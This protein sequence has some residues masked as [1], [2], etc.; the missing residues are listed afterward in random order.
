MNGLWRFFWFGL[1]LGVVTSH[2][3]PFARRISFVQADG[4]EVQLWGQGTEFH[5]VF[6]TLEGYTVVFDQ[7]RMSYCFARLSPDGSSLVSSGV[8][9]Q[10]ASPESLALPRHLRDTPA[11]RKADIQGRRMRWESL[12]QLAGAPEPN[13]GV[14]GTNSSPPMIQTIG[15][16][17]GLT[18][19][20]DFMDVPGRIPREE[21]ERFCNQVGYSGYGNRGSVRD[22]FYDNSTGMLT[23]TNVV[24]A[25]VQVPSRKTWYCDLTKDCGDQGRQLLN[26]AL[27]ALKNLPN[28][29]AEIL[30]ALRALS[31]DSRNRVLACNVFYAGGHGGVWSKG[32]WPHSSALGAPVE[33]FPGGQAVWRYQI[34]NLEDPLELGT[35]CHEN[36]HMLCNFP[37][38]Y[39]Y[40]D[41]SAGGAGWFCLMN[42]GSYAGGGHNPS[43][44]CAYLKL[45]AGWATVTELSESSRLTGQLT[46]FPDENCNHFYRYAKPGTPTEYF[47]LECRHQS[48]RDAGLPASGVAVWHIDE[49]GDHNNQNTATNGTHANYAITLVQADH[50]Y[51]LQRNENNG[52]SNDLFS[53][54]NQAPDFLN[55]IADDTAPPGNWWDGGWSGMVLQDFSA[56]APTMSF[57]IGDSGPPVMALP[58]QNA[59]VDLGQTATF[60]AMVRGARPLTYQW[61]FHGTNL[62]GANGGVL[63]IA[64]LSPAQAG[65]YRLMVSNSAGLAVSSDFNL[66][67]QPVS[68]LAQVLD[69]PGLLWTTGGPAGWEPQSWVTHD[70]V[71]AAVSGVCSNRQ[72]S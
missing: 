52:D 26:D 24:T 42:S 32:L 59:A 31:A 39:D 1:L 10:A 30:P 13:P 18:L 23:Y 28:Y 35:F 33:L 21:I 15:T 14:S 44:I 34:S 17:A 8:P 66:T 54:G 70:G 60:K 11:R 29:A 22:Y 2:A 71:G 27:A 47:L 53:A 50:Q 7:D 51:H 62:P 16:Q 25:Y 36:G 6:E 56:A 3:A 48:Y 12:M 57:E 46:A 72:S 58:S 64:A 19:L 5:A 41:D 43:Q 45:R 55:R 20:V 49:W 4:T 69:T 40:D 68:L 37:D 63:Q 9:A 38:I 61:L 67:V 65:S